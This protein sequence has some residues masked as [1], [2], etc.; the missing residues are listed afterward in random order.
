MKTLDEVI[1]E[2]HYWDTCDAFPESFYDFE[3]TTDALHYLK[4][5]REK[6]D[7]DW[8]QSYIA[9]RNEILFG[10]ED[11][12]PP[13]TWE[14]LKQME[15]KPVWIELLKGKWKGWDVIGG[16]DEDDF[17]VA[18]VTVRGDD[19]YKADLGK[20]WQAYRKERE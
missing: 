10:G 8:R 1:N 6:Q 7:E 12:N 13:L 19:Y 2:L 20:T 11:D 15:G 5:Y 16:F 17:G 3:V 14:E 9:V 4:E 18:M